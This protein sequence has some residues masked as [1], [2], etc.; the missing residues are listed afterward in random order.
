MIGDFVLLEGDVKDCAVDFDDEFFDAVLCDPPYGLS[1]MGKE[2]DHGVPGTPIW[3]E[4]YR[5][6]KPG[7]FLL[8]FG[9]TRTFHRL[10]CAVE[11]AGFEIR[12][13]LSWLY[14][15]GFPKSLDISKAIDKAAGIEREDLGRHPNWR[16]AKR[17]NGQSMGRVPNE[18][19]VT[20]PATDAARQ[21]AG[22]GT[23]LKPAWEP[24]I[25]AMKPLDGTFAENALRSGVAGLNVDAGRIAHQSD[26]DRAS[27]TPQGRATG[28]SGALAGKSENDRER[29]EF[30]RPDTTLG[31]WPANVLLDEEAAAALDEQSG[32]VGSSSGYV[33]APTSDLGG[34]SWKKGEHAQFHY[35]GTGG[36]SRFFYTAKAS[37]SEREAGLDCIEMV[38]ISCKAWDDAGLKV[39]LRVDTGQSVPRVTGVYGIPESAVSEWNTFLFGKRETGRSLPGIRFT[40]ATATSSITESKT[41]SWLVRSL[42]RESIP[43][44]NG[45]KPSGGSRVESAEHGTP[46]LTI[47]LGKA[48]SLRGVGTV[49]SGTQLRIRGNAGSPA[50]HPTVKP[51]ALC[52]YLAS[53]ILPPKRDTPRRLLVPFSGSGSEMIGALLAGWDEVWGI[54]INP[55]YNKIAEARLNHWNKEENQPKKKIKKGAGNKGSD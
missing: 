17:D 24:C 51:L 38:S 49:A 20:L 25:V 21:W 40:T 26:A 47:T 8:A 13:C 16:E 7:A 50:N 2:W 12:D 53:L 14:G 6:L 5:T 43:V 41:L 3:K 30:S 11:D 32:E 19:R 45:A 36:A 29:K 23:A 35:T 55:E 28:K 1:F 54:E 18:A 4:V 15:S 22:Y 48:V 27:A 10:T 44:V 31:R 37:R 9:G 33:G 42:T 34:S 46:L 39:Q 52:R